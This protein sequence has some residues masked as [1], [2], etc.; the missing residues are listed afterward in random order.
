MIEACGFEVFEDG[1][2]E[3]RGGGEVEEAVG[4]G[5]AFDIELV[6]ETAQG[7]V[8]FDILEL[9]LMVMDGLGE[10]GPEFLGVGLAGVFFVGG[11]EFGAEDFVAF[12]TTG[13]ADDFELG[14]QVTA[15]GDVVEGRDEFAMGEITRGAEDDN[16]AGFSTV[17]LDECFLEGVFH[18]CFF[19]WGF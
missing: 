6:E 4:G 1:F 3:F 17:L 12:F 11:F 14:R 8:A 18:E 9:A 2:E 5:A 16:G 15:C 7:F 13:E 19:V 10:T